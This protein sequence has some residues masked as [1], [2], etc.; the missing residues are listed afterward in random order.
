M[1]PGD[2]I[3]YKKQ[4]EAILND[5]HRK[6]LYK[7]LFELYANAMPNIYIKSDGTIGCYYSNEI[8]ILADKIRKQIMERD[9][10][11]FKANL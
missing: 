8:G 2:T 11:I 10:Q 6:E 7:A 1:K 5:S 9:N 4:R 3:D